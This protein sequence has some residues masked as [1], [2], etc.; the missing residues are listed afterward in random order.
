MYGDVSN[1]VYPAGE[2]KIQ[3]EMQIGGLP[4]S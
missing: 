1:V 2:R 4:E 3:R